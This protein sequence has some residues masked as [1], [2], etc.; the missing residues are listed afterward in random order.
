VFADKPR[1][2]VDPITRSVTNTKDDPQFGTAFAW[3][4][5]FGVRL[6]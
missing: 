4:A 5:S 6:P 3:D 1:I 2:V